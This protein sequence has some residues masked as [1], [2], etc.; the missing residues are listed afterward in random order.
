MH[1]AVV[2]LNPLVDESPAAGLLILPVLDDLVHGNVSLKLEI[3][4]LMLQIS[5]F[6]ICLERNWFPSD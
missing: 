1:G 4:I 6:N 2:E 5:M 3:L